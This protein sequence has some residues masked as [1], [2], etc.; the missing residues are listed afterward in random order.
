MW[1]YDGGLLLGARPPIV[2]G[3]ACKGE[4]RRAGA[5][6]AGVITAEDKDFV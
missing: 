3:R 2:G 1:R 6:E 5:M 4:A